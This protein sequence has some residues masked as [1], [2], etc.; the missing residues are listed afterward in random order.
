MM[1]VV[2]LLMIL[3]YKKEQINELR[4]KIVRINNGMFYNNSSGNNKNMV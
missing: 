1:K 3:N 2:K 4:F